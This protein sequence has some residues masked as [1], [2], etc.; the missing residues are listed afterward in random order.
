MMRCKI[1][2]QESN[3]IFKG[4]ILSKYNIKYFYCNQCGFLQTE[5]P[6][7]IDEAY[8]ESITSSDTGYI[9]RNIQLSQKLI[10]LLTL[11]FDKN[12][13]YLDYAAGYGVFVRLMRDIGFDFYWDD[14]YTNNLFASG[15]EYK[16]EERY[17]AVTT[18]ESFEHFVNPIDEIEKLLKL[19]KNII[20]T[21]ELIPKQIPNPQDWWY[22][23]LDHGQH[24]SFYSQKS[25]E[26][27]ANKY[28]L[29]YSNCGGVHLFTEKKISNYKLQ[30]LKL[31][32][33]GLHKL[34]QRGLKS[35]IWNDY[36]TI[37]MKK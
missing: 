13:K 11:F 17:E 37:S 19:S 32:K 20:F 35:K 25:F 5:E 15:F 8:N 22:Y 3:F 27:I 29:N 23:G 1:C 24:I 10:I 18:F 21:T 36:L 2:T 9:E 12:A 6:Y 26:F 7:W 31:Y 33:F 14:K 34:L 16:N 4:N 28:N 30:V